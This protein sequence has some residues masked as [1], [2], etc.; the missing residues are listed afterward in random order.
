LKKRIA[1][2]DFDGTITTRDT[3]L[4]FIKFQ[5]GTFR[6]WLGFIL[7]SPYIILYKLKIISNNTAKE[8]I[9]YYFWK[10]IPESDFQTD[11]DHFASEKLPQFLRPKA[12]QEI[13]QLKN[14]GFEVVIVSA[15]PENWIREWAKNFEAPVISTRLE[16]HE[17]RLTGRIAGKNCHGIEKVARIRAVYDTGSFDEIYAY[18]DTS[19]DKP[20]LSLANFQ[21]MKPFR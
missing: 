11:C 2:F 8:K 12:I 3:L 20:M 19:G 13:Q 18:G 1:F 17:N 14:K 21:F 15:S 7:H 16:T 5:K 6:Y 10:G 4:E 9:F